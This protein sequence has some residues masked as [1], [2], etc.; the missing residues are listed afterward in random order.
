MSLDDDSPFDRLPRIALDKMS[1]FS[2]SAPIVSP[3]DEQQERDAL[4]TDEER[5]NLHN[6]VYGCEEVIEETPGMQENSCRVL[7]ECLEAVPHTE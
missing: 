3:E 1:A 6:E 5:Q 4:T 7:R 2:F